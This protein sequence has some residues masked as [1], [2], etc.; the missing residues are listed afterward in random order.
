[1][2]IR[3][4]RKNFKTFMLLAR[5]IHQQ[6]PLFF[7]DDFL[8]KIFLELKSFSFMSGLNYKYGEKFNRKIADLYVKIKYKNHIQLY[9]N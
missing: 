2:N 5:E 3:S 1:M 6:N 4:I 8:S 7:N 9:K